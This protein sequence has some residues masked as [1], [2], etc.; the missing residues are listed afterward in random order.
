MCPFK[1]RHWAN[2]FTAIP[3]NRPPVSRLLSPSTTGSPRG[4]CLCKERLA[5]RPKSCP[6]IH[7]IP[8]RPSKDICFYVNTKLLS[9]KRKRKRS[10]SVLWQESLYHQK[11]KVKR[12]HKDATNA[13]DYTK[14]ADRLRKV[15]WRYYCHP[16]G[17]EKPMYGIPTFPLIAKDLLS[18]D[19]NLNI[20]K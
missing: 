8:K 19:T 10:D 11:M 2:L 16:T 7:P 20:P 18:K 1:H 6:H 3:R 14:I 5:N 9:A 17:V 12:Q 4:C 13:F 15:S